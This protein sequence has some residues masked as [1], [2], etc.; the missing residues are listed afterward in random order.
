MKTPFLHD[1]RNSAPSTT[2]NYATIHSKIVSAL[3]LAILLGTSGFVLAGPNTWNN[4]AGGNWSVATNWSTLAVPGTN[5]SVIFGNVGAGFPNTNDVAAATINSLTYDWNNQSQQITVIN[6]G[7]TLTVNSTNAAGSALFLEGSASAAPASAT[8]APAAIIGAGANLV[9]TGSGDLIVHIGNGTAGS[10]MATLDMS[11]LDNFNANV[12]RLLVGQANAGAAVNRPSGTLILAGTNHITLTGGSPQVMVQDSGSNAN[13]GTASVLTFGLLNFLNADTLRFGGQ[14]GN[15][16]INFNGIFSRPSLTIRNA[17]GV[18]P[19]TVIDFGYN[20]AAST[21]NSTTANADFSPATVDISANL[22]HVANGPIGTGSGGCTGTLTL[23]AGVLNVG[24]LEIGYGNATGVSGP[25][26]GTLNVNNNGSFS[27]GALVQANTMLRLAR[28]NGGSG[29]VTGTLSVSGGTVEANSIVSGGGVSSIILNSGSTLVVSNTAGSLLFPIRNF[30]VSGAALTIPALNGGA[31]V[32]VSNLTVSGSTNIINISSVPPIGSYP[33][34]FT[35]INY[36][37]GYTA[38][39][40]PLSLGTLPPASPSY[41]GTLVDTGGGVIQLRLTAGPVTT[42]ALHWTGAIDGNWDLGTVNWS[43]L[44]NPTNY[45]DGSAPL[46]DDTSSQT[47]VSLDTALSPGSITV[48]NNTRQ[49]TFGGSGNIAGAGTLAKAGPGTLTVVNEGVDTIGNVVINNG[50]LQIGTN[51]LNGA[52]AAINITNNG[53]LVV[54][55]AGSLTLSSAISGSGSLTEIGSGALI[56][57]GANSYTGPTVVSNGTLQVDGTSSGSGAVTTAVGTLLA[58]SGTVDG[59]IT[60]GG[61]MNPGPVGGVGTFTANGGLT[62][63]SGGALSFDLSALNPGSSGFNDSINVTGNLNVNSNAITVNFDGTPQNGAQYTLFTYTGALS[64]SFNPVISGTH[65]A[66]SLNTATPPNVSLSINSSSGADLKWSSTSD[67]TWN[68]STINWFNVDN[69]TPSVFYAGDTVLLDDTSGVAPTLNIPSG[70]NVSPSVITNSSTNNA[71]TI[72]GAGHITGGASIVKY[73]VSTL[74]ISTAN[75]FSGPVDVQAGTL[76]TGNGSALGSTTSGTT[77]E[78]GATLDISGQNLGGEAI[79]I[80][81]SGSAGQGALINSGGGQAQAL[82]QLILAGDATIGGSGLL[83]MNNSGGG[84]SLSTSAQP[85]NLTK[86]GPNQFTLQNFASVDAALGN[87]DIQQGIIEF[88]GLTPGMGDPTFT[89]TVEAGAELSFSQSTVAWN[90]QFVFN[91]DGTA[92]TVNVGTSASPELDGP[93][94]LHG[95]CVFN[96]GGISLTI[97]NTISGD[98]GVIKNAGAPMILTGPTLYTG[99]TTVS[100]GE[101]RL[102][103]T[104]NLSGSTNIIINAGASLS[105]TGTVSSTLTLANGHTLSG[106]GVL[107]G[108]LIANAGSTVAPAV[109][110]G[111]SPTGILTVSNTIALSGTNIM[112]LDPANGTNDVLKSGS[113]I[114]YGGILSLTNLSNPLVN[115]SSFKLFSAPSYS[116]S[117]SGIIPASPGAGQAWDTSALRT[118]GTIKVVGTTPPTIGSIA[119]VGTSVVFTGSNGGASNTY[120]V[121]ASTNVSAPLTN[122]SRIATNT[123][124]GTGHFAFTNTLNPSMPQRF[125]RLQLP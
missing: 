15:A 65:F 44:G 20:A 14:K 13:G 42:L 56:L 50:T 25:T 21:G 90:K 73:G 105:V 114:A 91:G 38:G 119:V 62:V 27:A 123:F 28:T 82:R 104:A 49:Y 118:T 85:F 37:S 93:V 64:G 31:T 106:H 77:V 115:G 80:S 96:V 9:L 26:T 32:A 125:F 66:A 43:F 101:L 58:G 120:Y 84:A 51:D 34:T 19:C 103:G 4:A 94:T 6:P 39:A 36:Q 87:I 1:I 5:D 112:Q 121:L 22:L 99:D 111:I 52:I 2:T 78:S 69:S 7:E 11:G 68:S 124:D 102:I 60:V 86:V 17:D 35:L 45:F 109:T 23:G 12:G 88:S 92:T 95:G 47:N 97:T 18:S 41:S 70:V 10:H 61:Q 3:A 81:G 54:D 107:N 33:A 117:F 53:V 8:L 76:V 55:R 83:G 16:N 75:S 122:W 74:I 72:S 57:S 98:G 30:G 46:F 79:T 116:G 48:S 24:A 71:F 100:S 59:A 89:N 63:S 40:G 67:T 29:V 108:S 113:S 110:P